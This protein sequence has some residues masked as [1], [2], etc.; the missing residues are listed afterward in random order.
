MHVKWLTMG[1]AS[2]MAFSAVA[3]AQDMEEFKTRMGT[4]AAATK[5]DMNEALRQYLEIRIQYA[6]PEVD[7]SLGRAYQRMNQCSEAQY[8]FT[9]VMVAYDLP[10]TNPIYKRAVNAYDEIADCE[11]WQKVMVECSVPVGGHAVIDGEQLSECWDRAYSFKD[12]EHVIELVDK[13]GKKI[14]KKV[15][16]KSGEEQK[17]VAIA[18][19]AKVK[20]VE[21]VVEIENVVFEKEKFHPAL[22]W[23]LI[24]GGAAIVAVGGFMNGYAGEAK[25]SEQKFADLH[26]ISTSEKN[27]EYFAKRRDE[28][29]DDVKA[30]NIAMYSLIGVGSV[31]VVTGVAL[32][33]VSAVSDK[34][35]IE[36][37]DDGVKAYFSPTADGLALGL[38][39]NF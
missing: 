25:V 24:A 4:A 34:E 39:M 23:G 17:T 21:K 5:V 11:S 16:T 10:E 2:L 7:Y 1:F 29:H 20:E 15:T 27:R 3:Q 36:K 33:I 12:G 22:Y 31:A 35:H 28:A 38:G 14:E 13:D 19:P 9:Q 6:G 26:A 37:K 32:A 18:F 30:R 8:Y